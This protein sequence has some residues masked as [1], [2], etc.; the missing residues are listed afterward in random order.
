MVMTRSARGW[1]RAAGRLRPGGKVRGNGGGRG[2][3]RVA[4]EG[5]AP[6]QADQRRVAVES[7][8]GAALVVAQPQFL[9]AVLMETLDRPAL[10]SQSELLGQRA[11]AQAPGEVPL[12]LVVLARQGPLAD[13]PAERAGLIATGAWTR[14]RQA[15]RW[16]PRCCGSSTVTLVQRLVA[17]ALVNS[18]LLCNGPT[19]TGCGWMRGRPGRRVGGSGWRAALRTSAGRR[20]PTTLLT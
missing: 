20:T 5:I 4:E 13:Q 2:Q 9:L 14:S 3:P 15:K 18:W 8:P 6:H 1:R 17:T 10:V 7:W 12:G 16:V 11:V 19:C